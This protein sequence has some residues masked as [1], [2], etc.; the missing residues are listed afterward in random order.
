MLLKENLHQNQAQEGKGIFHDQLGL[1]E[2][3]RT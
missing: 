3:E 2:E 1:G